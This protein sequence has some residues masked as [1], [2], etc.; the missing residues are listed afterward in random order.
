MAITGTNGGRERGRAA[1][2]KP[3]PKT[4]APAPQAKPTFRKHRGGGTRPLRRPSLPSKIELSRRSLIAVCAAVLALAAAIAL[5]R[6]AMAGGAAAEAPRTETAAEAKT[7]QAKK[8]EKNEQEPTSTPRSEWRAGEMPYL[9]QIDPT[10]KDKPYAGGT[11]EKNGCGPTALSMVYIYLTGNTNMGP[12]EMAA[13]SEQNGYVE[14]GMTRWSFMETGA[15]S[16]GLTSTGIG[17]GAG[18]IRAALAA[19]EPVICSIVPGT[20]TKV[21]HFM[22]LTSIDEYG[23]VTIHDPNSVGNSKRAW[24]IDLIVR[25][26]AAAW[27]F[28]KTT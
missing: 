17:A 1:S 14:A 8:E 15:Q 9:Y 26:C 25:E 19:G 28:K 24:D 2:R 5:G 10:W 4:G 3:A 7:S 11:M 21:G 12:V 27:S 13:F 23:E 22:V 20:F 6:G 18:Q 16:L